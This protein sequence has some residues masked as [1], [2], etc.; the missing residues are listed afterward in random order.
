MHRLTHGSQW[1]HAEFQTQT[2]YVVDIFYII[3]LF[4]SRASIIFLLERLQ[5][6]RQR[7][8]WISSLGVLTLW[9]IASVFAVSLKCNLSHPWI[10]YNVQCTGLVS[11]AITLCTCNGMELN[12]G[13]FLGGRQLKSW[14]L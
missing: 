1:T 7:P 14:A 11:T 12:L 8:I 13:S 5:G 4:C 9:F 10:Q 3:V 2:Q 6:L